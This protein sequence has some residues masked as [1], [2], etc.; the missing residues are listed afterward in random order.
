MTLE[1]IDDK[2]LLRGAL[3]SAVRLALIRHNIELEP[4]T[5]TE[6]EIAM[7]A[8]G[9]C[10]G[11]ECCDDIAIPEVT[12]LLRRLSVNKSVRELST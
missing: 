7:D 1:D 11:E 9:A 5:A 8:A 6:E 4:D 3:F 10:F 2:D 12:E